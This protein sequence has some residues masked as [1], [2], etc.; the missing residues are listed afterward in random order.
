MNEEWRSIY[1]YEGYYEVSNFGRIRSVER[2]IKYKNGRMIRLKERI[3]RLTLDRYGYAF[4]GAHM[5]GI[6][7]L[8]FVHRAVCLAF[9]GV[10]PDNCTEINHKN[11]IKSDN[12]F[13]NLEYCDAK[14]NMHHAIALGLVNNK[15][16][17]NHH[18]IHKQA[19]ID[20]AYNLLKV[21]VKN[22][23]VEEITGV[24]YS[25][26]CDLKAGKTWGKSRL[27]P[28]KIKKDPPKYEE[29]IRVNE[30]FKLGLSFEEIWIATGIHFDRVLMYIATA[31][32]YNPWPYS[33][34]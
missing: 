7:K 19:Q 33:E 14:Y 23:E 21:G 29:H 22:K 6:N 11:G 34:P 17:N 4:F 12:R 2:T 30:L 27:I 5:N 31:L 3:L 26:L 18:A 9:L 1:R 16:E 10:I 24:K 13:E 25:T 15:G 28:V 8:M 20:E 32:K